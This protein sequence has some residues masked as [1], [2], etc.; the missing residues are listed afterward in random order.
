[1]DALRGLP[2][3]TF[4]TAFILTLCVLGLGCACLLIEYNIQQTTYG[5]V[6]FGLTYTVEDGAPVVS[7]T[8]TD[9]TVTLLPADSRP[10]AETAVPA[11]VRL[12]AALWRGE[13][14]AAERFWEW[15]MRE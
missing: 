5:R 6:D 7:R 3:R 12:L 14:E 15:V 11:P 9:A 13:N 8:D 4:F 1:M 2:W 10:L